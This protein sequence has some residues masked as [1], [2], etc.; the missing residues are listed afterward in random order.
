VLPGSRAFVYHLSRRARRAG[1][2]VVLNTRATR[3]LPAETGVETDKGK[4]R[5]SRAVVLAGGDFSAGEDFRREFASPAHLPLPAVNPLAE[6][7]CQRMAREAGGV[8]VNGDLAFGDPRYRFRPPARGPWWLAL[9][10]VRPVT[11][12]MRFALR[13]LPPALVRPFVLSF[14]TTAL[15]PEASLLD[16]GARLVNADGEEFRQPGESLGHAIA[17]QPGRHAYFLL[18]GAL[19]D[20][21]SRWPNYISTAPGVAYAYIDDYQRTRPDLVAQA[22]TVEELARMRGLPRLPQDRLGKGPFL[23]LGPVHS[24]LVLADGG[25]AVSPRMEVLDAGGKPIPGLYAAG[26]AGQGGL[27][28]RGH[29]HHLAWA[30][31]SGRIAGASAAG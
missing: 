6:G 8:I 30:F 19:I 25:L 1:V 14:L 13:R 24:C 5:A 23:L 4:F 9:P 28:L 27:L 17:R 29:G 16:Q 2:R 11:S 22:A 10:P 3:L 15:A 21:F 20:S 7:D 31:V 18:D 12:L 26:S